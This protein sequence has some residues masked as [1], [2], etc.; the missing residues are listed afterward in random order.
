MRFLAMPTLV[1]ACLLSVPGAHAQVPPGG[2]ED[3]GVY[4]GGMGG[5]G[6]GRHGGMMGGS[7]R[8]RMEFPTQEEIEGP[9]TPAALRDLVG[10]DEAGSARYT[11]RYT[12]HMD[13]TSAARDSLRTAM[14]GLRDARDA[15]DRE[16]MR[17][18]FTSARPSSRG[19][20]RTS[21]SVTKPSSRKRKSR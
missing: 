13:T 7:W 5:R 21:Q 1:L 15:G 20:G 2:V 16:A 19:S 3:G 11:A 10:L 4:G 12:S 8:G 17:P 6:M 18:P 14:R 9:P